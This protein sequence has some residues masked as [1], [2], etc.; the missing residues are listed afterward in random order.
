MSLRDTVHRSVPTGPVRGS[1]PDPD[2]E[3]TADTR[4]ERL[5][6]SVGAAER[7][8]WTATVAAVVL[9]VVLATYGLG[10]GLVEVNPV[11]RRTLASLDVLSL[12]G[13]KLVALATGA[14]CRLAVGDRYGPLVPV[15]PAVPSL[16]LVCVNTV[17]IAVVV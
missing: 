3:D 13:L 7:G 12:C 14:Y 11:A 8:L 16:A 17:V 4:W 10:F 9:D 15:G 2:P 6:R 1:E 5:L